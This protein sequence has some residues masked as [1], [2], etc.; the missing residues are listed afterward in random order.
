MQ[1]S[2][3]P[4]NCNGNLF[5]GVAGSYSVDFPD[6]GDFLSSYLGNHITGEQP[7]LGSRRTR[8]NYLYCWGM[9]TNPM[10]SAKRRTARIKFMMGPAAITASRCQR[11]F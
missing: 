7:N 9:K 4:D 6:G 8:L 11:L 1:R 2:I 5:I 10:Y 3:F